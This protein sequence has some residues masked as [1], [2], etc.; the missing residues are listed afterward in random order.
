MYAFTS[1]GTQ[2]GRY[3]HGQIDGPWGVTIDGNDN[4]WVANFGELGFHGA[5]TGRLTHLAG[6]NEATRPKGTNPGD[7]LSPPKT[8]YTLPNQ[9]NEILLANLQPL[10]GQDGPTMFIP[11][12]RVTAL[13]FDAAGNIW[14]C[15]NW[16][17]IF[18][19]DAIGDPVDHAASN[20]GGDGMVIFVGMAKP[21]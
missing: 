14:C 19:L 18:L 6:A 20:P 13:N 4:V 17:P 10:Y 3:N 1:D 15:N 11:F 8:G 7:V 12:M 16:K 5:F 2:I 21:R 9:G